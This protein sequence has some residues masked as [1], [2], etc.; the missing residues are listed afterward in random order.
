MDRGR[1]RVDGEIWIEGEWI[2]GEASIEGE[3]LIDGDE[4]IELRGMDKGR[5]SLIGMDRR[6]D[7]I[8][9]DNGIDMGKERWMERER[10]AKE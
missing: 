4:W 7:E 3:E 6:K 1:H 9:M 2:E 5:E 10:Y 8:L